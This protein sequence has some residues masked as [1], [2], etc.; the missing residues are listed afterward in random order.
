M[1]KP[2]DHGKGKPMGKM[3]PKKMDSKKDPKKAGDKDKP[4][5]GN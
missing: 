2:M 4:K 3:D 1:G 5:T